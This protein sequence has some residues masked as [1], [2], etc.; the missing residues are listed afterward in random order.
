MAAR[1]FING[2]HPAAGERLVSAKER[3]IVAVSPARTAAF[4]ILLRGAR[5][6]VRGRAAAF[7]AS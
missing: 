6:F 5:V 4:N 1:E 3:L 7:R 2:Y